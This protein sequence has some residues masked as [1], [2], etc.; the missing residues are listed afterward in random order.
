M[1]KK[2]AEAKDKSSTPASARTK[3][4]TKR[5][6][7]ASTTKS[8]ASKPS[9]PAKAAATG[10][11]PMIDTSLAAQAAAAMLVNR[12]RASGDTEARSSIIQQLKADLNKSPSHA[13]SNVLNKSTPEGARK[14]SATPFD[15]KQV[16]HNQTRGADLTRSGVPRRTSG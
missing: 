4:T 13:V 12:N 2:K 7:P 6:A 5:E 9:K 16:G 1:G 10:D 15:Q 8:A 11:T 3:P 14:P